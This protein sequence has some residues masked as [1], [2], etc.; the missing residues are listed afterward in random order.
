MSELSESPDKSD[1]RKNTKK[2]SMVKH[3]SSGQYQCLRIV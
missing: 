2:Q 1:L 3:P